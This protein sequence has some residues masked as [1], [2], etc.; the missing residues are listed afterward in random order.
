MAAVTVVAVD[1]AVAAVVTDFNGFGR[2]GSSL[3][4]CFYRRIKGPKQNGCTDEK[5]K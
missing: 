4:R 3:W 2:A 1:T 5:I